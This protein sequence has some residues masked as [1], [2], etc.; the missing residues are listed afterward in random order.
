MDLMRFNMKILITAF[1]LLATNVFALELRRTDSPTATVQSGTSFNF[2]NTTI[3]TCSSCG[4]ATGAVNIVLDGIAD[5]GF[6]TVDMTDTSTATHTFVMAGMTFLYNPP[7]AARATGKVISYGF[8]RI[9]TKI[10]V[11]AIEF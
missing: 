4:A 7:Q 6:Y 11:T 9:G 1:L 2:N 5:G 8:H 3:I 10:L